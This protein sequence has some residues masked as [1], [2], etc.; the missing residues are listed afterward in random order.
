MGLNTP[1]SLPFLKC[2]LKSADAG[3]QG[4][5]ASVFLGNRQMKMTQQLGKSLSKELQS[6]LGWA[7]LEWEVWEFLPKAGSM[8]HGCV[9]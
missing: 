7:G 1:A 9:L 6:R 4:L 5:I 8:P 2:L 3:H